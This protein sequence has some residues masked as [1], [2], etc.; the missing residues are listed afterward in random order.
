MGEAERPVLGS[1]VSSQMYDA[2]QAQKRTPA[3]PKKTKKRS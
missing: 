3:R 2:G 1:M